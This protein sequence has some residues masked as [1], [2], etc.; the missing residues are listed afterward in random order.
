M[1]GGSLTSCNLVLTIQ[2]AQPARL[3]GFLDLLEVFAATSIRDLLLALLVA[4]LAA[5][6]A[7]Y[8]QDRDGFAS[9]KSISKS[10]E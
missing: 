9:I 2:L 7:L 8:L 3:D 5:L 10:G 4:I 1:M 6:M